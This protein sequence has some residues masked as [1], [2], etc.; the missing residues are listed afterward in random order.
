MK[1]S[2]EYTI[3]DRCL[4]GGE[5]AVPIAN[6]AHENDVRILA[7]RVA[8]AVGKAC[9]VD[10][11]FALFKLRNLVV[12]DELNRILDRDDPH[13]LGGIN[14]LNQC[15]NGGAFALAGWA[16]YQHQSAGDGEHIF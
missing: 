14:F 3:T 7:H 15:S 12:E 8:N 13:G 1:E 5:D 9:S 2:D 11:N 4:D 6:F 16:R 10:S